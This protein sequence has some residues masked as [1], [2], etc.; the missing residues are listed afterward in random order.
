ME[1]RLD[2]KDEG[3]LSVAGVFAITG[4]VDPASPAEFCGLKAGNR[5]LSHTSYTY[6]NNI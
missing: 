6:K 4:A 5:V 3:R 2:I 1:S